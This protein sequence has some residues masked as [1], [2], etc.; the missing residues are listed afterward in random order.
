MKSLGK[1]LGNFT[2]KNDNER[3]LF[4]VLFYENGISFDA[5]MLKGITEVEEAFKAFKK[6]NDSWI[7]GD[8]DKSDIMERV[9]KLLNNYQ[10]ELAEY[11]YSDEELD[12]EGNL[13]EKYEGIDEKSK[14]SIYFDYIKEN[15]ELKDIE[16]AEFESKIFNKEIGE[17]YVE[18]FEDA[19]N[20]AEFY[21]YKTES[22]G[23]S[24]IM[25]VDDKIKIGFVEK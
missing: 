4:K 11:F 23:D 22:G 9:L 6:I 2:V 17:Y 24:Y 15:K 8:Y 5:K 3:Q 13:I 19:K 1:F 16:R 20:N 12:E 10:E 7:T 21:S 14:F 18:N 25:V